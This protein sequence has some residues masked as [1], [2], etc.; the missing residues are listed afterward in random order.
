V[1]NHLGLLRSSGGLKKRRALREDQRITLFIEKKKEGK[2]NIKKWDRQNIFPFGFVIRSSVAA[3]GFDFSSEL[4]SEIDITAPLSS[5]YLVERATLFEHTS[6]HGQYFYPQGTHNVQLT[7]QD[8][9]SIH[10]LRC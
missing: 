1:I 7:V 3:L 9:A 6:K 10:L 5:Q 4:E 2:L 8:F